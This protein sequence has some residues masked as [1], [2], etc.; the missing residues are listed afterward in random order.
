MIVMK[1]MTEDK[2]SWSFQLRRARKPLE[3]DDVTQS[4]IVY[5]RKISAANCKSAVANLWQLIVQI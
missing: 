3:H 4:V 2:D 5:L 1:V